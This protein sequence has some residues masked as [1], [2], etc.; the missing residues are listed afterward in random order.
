MP[1]SLHL[2]QQ[3]GREVIW[4]NNLFVRIYLF[5]CLFSCC[6]DFLFQRLHLICLVCKAI[7]NPYAC[8]VPI[9]KLSVQ[10]TYRK[11]VGNI[12]PSTLVESVEF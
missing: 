8:T 2:R 5:I 6:S 7:H 11:S 12:K 4:N 9:L 10:A 1:D 3:T